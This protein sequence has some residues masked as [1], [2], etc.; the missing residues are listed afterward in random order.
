MRLV[1]DSKAAGAKFRNQLAGLADR[2]DAAMTATANILK[3]MIEDAAKADIA[4]SGNFGSRWTEGLHVDVEQVGATGNMRLSMRHD[5]PYAGIFEQG[6]RIEGH[7]YLWIPLSGTDAEGKQ[8]SE[9]GEQLYSVQR[10]TGGPLLFS[11][12]DK[13]PKYFGI[14]S[15]TIPKKWHLRDIQLSVMGNFRA[16]F[17]QQFRQ[18]YG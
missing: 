17:D 12:A 1:I 15:V 3:S 5:I 11:M 9:Y 16:V 14:E 2:F 4:S 8:A 10:K 7:P 18:L 6:G 13:M